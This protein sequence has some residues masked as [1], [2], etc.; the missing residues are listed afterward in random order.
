MTIV[1]SLNPAVFSAHQLARPVTLRGEYRVNPLYVQESSSDRVTLRLRFPDAD[2]E[3][4]YGACRQYLPDEV[5][6]DRAALAAIET[7]RLAPVLG[8]LVKRRV[9]LDLPARYY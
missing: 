2:Y 1:A 5:V 6:V 3:D 8:D 7:D 4:E 9:I